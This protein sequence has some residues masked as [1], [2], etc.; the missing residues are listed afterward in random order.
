[1]SQRLLGLVLA[2]VGCILVFFTSSKAKDEKLVVLSL[3]GGSIAIGF[4]LKM[5]VEG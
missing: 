4:G 5:M 2:F 3:I 1:M